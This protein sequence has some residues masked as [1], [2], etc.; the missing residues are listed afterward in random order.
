MADIRH[1]FL[2]EVILLGAMIS[3]KNIDKC[4]GA[5]HALNQ[6]SFDI[7]EG[8]TLA[9]VGE[10][11]AGKSTLT[12]ILT[13]AHQRDSGE[14]YFEG[15]QVELKSPLEAKNRGISQLYQHAEIVEELSVAEN[16]FLGE[17]GYSQKGSVSLK[18]LYEKAEKALQKYEIKINPRIPMKYLSVA[19]QQ[20]IALVK[21]LNRKPKL[22]ILD[23]P[24]AVLSDKEVEIL[25]RIIKKL[26]EEKTTIIYIS[27]RLDEIFKV[28]HRIAIMRDGRLITILEN[29]N[30]THEDLVT[31]MLGRKLSSMFPRKKE[32]ISEVEIFSVEGLCNDRVKDI[33]FC[34]KKGEILGIVGLVGSGRTE[35]ARAI[36]GL[37]RIQKGSIFIEGKKVVIKS[38]KAAVGQ[39]L[40]LAPEDRKGEGVVL[41]RSI[42]E[43]ITYPLLKRFFP[44]ALNKQKKEES[45][46]NELKA[47]IRIKAPSVDTL[48]N[49]LSG[50]NQQKVVVARV[51]AVQPKI[52]IIDEPTQGIDV[53][54]KAEI[55]NL[56]RELAD[57]GMGVIVIS[58]EMEEAIGLSN[59]LLVMREGKICGELQ[60]GFMEPKQILDCM[61][62]SKKMESGNWERKCEQV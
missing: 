34:L 6:I 44:F 1:A 26:Q 32:I 24:T 41:G 55:Y 57:Q 35:L 58:S 50:G 10:N 60:E 30:V 2:E 11:G 45:Y 19:E 49:E 25:F 7:N 12:K 16:I 14:I 52:L 18:Q 31:H 8:E 15:K 47:K 42:K 39:G 62:Q 46:T 5:V 22:I 28:S 13:G 20:L 4:F 36:M 9:L 27:H 53:G 37:D 38:P 43:N 3:L 61:Y 23:E 51:L 40:F 21:V 29:Q 54:A 48:C 33:S 59:R 17:I 56:I